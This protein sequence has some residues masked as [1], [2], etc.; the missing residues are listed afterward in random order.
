MANSQEALEREI[1]ELRQLL[2]AGASLV[3]ALLDGDDVEQ[4]A[5]DWL[6]RIDAL[7]T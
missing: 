6:A 7:S 2:Q 4:L 1:A 3:S 5:R